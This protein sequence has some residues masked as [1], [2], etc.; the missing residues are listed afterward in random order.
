M[1]NSCSKFLMRFTSLMDRD[2]TPDFEIPEKECVCTKEFLPHIG[3]DKKIYSN[4]CLC[5]CN[6]NK[7]CILYKKKKKNIL[8]MREVI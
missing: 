2:I 5:E 7:K 1:K 8:W 3:E 6:N 4:K